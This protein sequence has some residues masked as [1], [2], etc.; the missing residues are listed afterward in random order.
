MFKKFGPGLL[1]AAAFVGPGTLAMCTLAGARFG[2]ALIWAL[3]VSIMATII[4]QG[5]AARI[6]LVTQRGLVDVVRRELRTPWIRKA[7][8]LVVLGA[9]LVGNAAYQAGNIGGAVLGLGQ[10]LPFEWLAPYLPLILGGTIFALLWFSTYK[11]LE[12]IFVSLVAIMGLGF[13]LCALLVRPSLVAILKGMF[14][15][16]LPQDSLLTVIALVGTTVVPYNLFLHAALVGEKWKS[17][18]DLRT[19]KWDTVLSLS[20][21]GLVS[22]A[23]LVTAAGAPIS[24]VDHVLDMAR[25][26]EPLLGKMAVY[27]MS[28]GLMAAGFTS[29]ITAPLA[30]A[31]VAGNCFGWEGGMRN[32]RFKMVWSLVLCCG[33]F[34]LSFDIRPMEIIQFAQ[35]ANGLLLPIMALM[36]LWAVNR[37][38][39]MGDYV[40]RPLQNLMGL[41]IVVFSIFLGAKSIIKVLGD[42]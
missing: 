25:G 38:S 27:S 13:V 14:I 22:L 9:I 11:G 12:R 15:P 35:V 19:V 23:I 4:L 18:E 20:V 21:G 17:M 16:S 2:Y 33:V 28:L 29:A 41:A 37:R 39:V 10:L 8:L 7:V 5:M 6:G 34:F 40:N 36:L 3:F 30:A 1:I 42:L 31:Y 26:L 24:K 32:K